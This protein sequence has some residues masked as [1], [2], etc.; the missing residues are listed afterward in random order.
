MRV[1]VS[2]GCDVET[3]SI[4]RNVSSAADSHLLWSQLLRYQ[5][6]G[7]ILGAGSCS[8]QSADRGLK[9]MGILFDST[10]TIYNVQEIDGIRLLLL[11]NPAGNHREWMGDWS[12]NSPL[13]TQ[14]MKHKMNYKKANDNVF[15]MEFNDFCNIF[16]FIYI[17]KW[18]DERKWR[19][20][21]FS[22][23]WSKS[24]QF[25]SSNRNVLVSTKRGVSSRGRREIRTC[26]GLPSSKNPECSTE[27]NPYYS[28]EVYEPTEIRLTVRQTNE[29]GQ[30]PANLRHVGIYILKN[31]NGSSFARHTQITGDILVA[32][33]GHAVM[34]RSLNLDCVLQPGKYEILVA[35]LHA[36]MEGHFKLGITSNQNIGVAQLW[37]PTQIEPT[38]EDPNEIDDGDPKD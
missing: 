30:A 34:L 14:R 31:R 19:A 1:I 28:L 22:G 4:R 33:T 25:V 29:Q 38:D 2:I 13:W 36:G 7:F 32:G 10:Y 6:N 5:H 18:R 12:D 16:R 21:E 9:D 20:I 37:P 17:C 27:N 8:L 3:V 23:C 15:W 24:I 11:R 35:L 26:G